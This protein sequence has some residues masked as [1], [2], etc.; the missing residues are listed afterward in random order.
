MEQDSFTE[1]IRRKLPS[2]RPAEKRAARLFLDSPEDVLLHSASALAERAETSDATIIRTVRA[3]DFSGMDD[4]RR[5]IAEEL[6]NP[7]SPSNRL[8]RTLQELDDDAGTST[9][10]LC[11]QIHRQS[12][13]EIQKNISPGLFEAAVDYIGAAGAI[14]A[15]GMGPSA[16]MADYFALQLGRFGVRAESVTEGGIAL[17]DHLLRIRSGDLVLIFAYS[18]LYPELKA[19]LARIRETQA[20]AILFTDKL[21]DLLFREVDIILPVPRGKSDM[22]SLHAATLALIEALLIGVAMRRPEQSFD[23]LRRL[24]ELRS[25][26]RGKS[27]TTDRGEGFK[28][29]SGSE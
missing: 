3:L 19:L 26:I 4:M 20:A 29:E 12:L 15:F 18:G 25:E 21:G 11:L 6:R 8:A 27:G 9:L 7:P 14:F 24:H 10:D 17:A 1:K 2:L 16:A 22:L 23:S 13:A 5:A 28:G